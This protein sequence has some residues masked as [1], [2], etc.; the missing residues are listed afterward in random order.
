MVCADDRPFSALQ[1]LSRVYL[2]APTEG[3]FGCGEQF[4][5]LF[6]C[7]NPTWFEWGKDVFVMREHKPPPKT[8]NVG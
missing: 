7:F 6:S 2:G 8:I 3:A 4:W 1:Q 5:L